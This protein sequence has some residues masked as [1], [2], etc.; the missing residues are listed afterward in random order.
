MNTNKN[1]FDEPVPKINVPLLLPKKYI[2]EKRKY[3]KGD[4]INKIQN[5][6]NIIFDKFSKKPGRP[7]KI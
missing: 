7:K 3:T 4:Q 6:I 5:K 2:K 1:I